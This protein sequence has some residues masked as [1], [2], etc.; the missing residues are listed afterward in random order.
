MGFLPSIFTPD[1]LIDLNTCDGFFVLQNVN[2]VQ[3][4]YIILFLNEIY[5]GGIG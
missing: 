4:I 3:T 5:W 2:A 1:E